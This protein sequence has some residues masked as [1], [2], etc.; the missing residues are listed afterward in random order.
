[1]TCPWGMRTEGGLSVTRN[2]SAPF[3]IPWLA[4]PSCMLPPSLVLIELCYVL[5]VFVHALLSIGR[6]GETEAEE[7]KSEKS[8]YILF[9]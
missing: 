3:L 9:R 6:H 2:L 4:A 8:T 5:K 1:M 7:Y